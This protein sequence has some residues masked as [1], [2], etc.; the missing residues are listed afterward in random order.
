M[1]KFS[2]LHISD[3]HIGNFVY[4]KVEDLA[5]SIVEAIEDHDKHVNC[6]VV[7]GDIFDGRSDDSEKNIKDAVTFFKR[8]CIELNKKSANNIGLSDFILVPGNHDQIRTEEGDTLYI[9]KKFLKSFYSKD[10]FERNY[11]S[12]HLYT[13]KIFE[14]EK[15]AIVGLNSCMIEPQA[16]IDDETKWLKNIKFENKNDIQKI[17]DA[18]KEQKKWD[19]YGMISK[20]Q[21]RDAFDELNKQLK[22][23]NEYSILTC[24]HHHFYPFPEI[25]DKYGDS[26]LIRNF[27]NVI[28]KLQKSNVKVVLHGHKHLPII[29][30]VTN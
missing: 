9:F 25:Y 19:D 27:T 5:I 10:Y 13:I 3:L 12:D 24:F 29:R 8:L 1:G 21:L 17:I 30:P 16:L 14:T 23:P 15:V 20:S 22:D 26:S 4:D 6:I 2:I 28:D 18:L 7:T 11:N